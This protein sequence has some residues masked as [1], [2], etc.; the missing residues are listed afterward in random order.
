MQLVRGHTG[1]LGAL[2]GAI[3]TVLPA[4]GTAQFIYVNDNVPTTNT[5]SGFVVDPLTGALTAVP[6]S[7][8]PTGGAGSASLN[9]DAIDVVI[10]AGRLYATNAISNSVSAFTIGPTGALTPIP[11]SPF[12][13][14]NASLGVRPTGIAID[15]VGARLFVADFISNNVAVFDI[16]SNGALSHVPSSPF[17]VTASP[18]A[19]EIDSANSLLFASHSANGVG[20]YS[21]GAGGSL[22]AIPG[23][24]FAAAGGERGLDL[25]AGSSRIY[26]ADGTTNTVS[27]FGVGGGGTLTAL[28]GSPFGAGT[29]PT[30]V[31]FH[32]SLSVLYVSNGTSSDVSVYSI[33]GNGTLTAIGGSPFASGGTGTSGMVIDMTNANFANGLLFAINGDAN[34]SPSRDV[35]V[36]SIAASGALTAVAGSPF[37]TGATS[38]APS[39]IA[40]AILDSDGDGVKDSEDNCPLA[41]NPGQEDTDGDGIGNACDTDCTAGAANCVPGRGK[42]STDCYA[43][44]HAATIPPPSTINGLSDYRV[45]CQNGNAGCDFDNDGTDDHCTF[46]V[47]VCINNHDPRISSTCSPAQIASYELIRPRSNSTDAADQ[48]NTN[49]LKKAMSGGTCDNDQSRSCLVNGDCLGGGQC[50]GAPVIGVP[51]VK[52][53]TVLIAGATNSDP[54][55]CSNVME[56][57]IPL[58]GSPGGYRTRSKNFR[59][60]VRNLAGVLDTDVLKLTCFPAP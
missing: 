23:S 26:V 3:V 47:R 15:A 40:L 30:G 37:S 43:E 33:A 6:G 32:P 56:I 27:G 9:I 41:D 57:K 2:L 39:S 8:F 7:P 20:V 45:G 14:A 35:S 21:I 4:I 16:A 19:L 18:L 24:P 55:S 17:T 48:A 58:R 38:G 1:A 46:H 53:T 51:F 54:D 25:S 10:T 13:T 50:T 36:F 60:R 29:A 28:P 5:I 52:R 34:P 59:A 42:T 12:P 11:G 31:L 49:E 44:W 22:S